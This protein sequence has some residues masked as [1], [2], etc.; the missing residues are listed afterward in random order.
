MADAQPAGQQRVR[1]PQVGGVGHWGH[2]WE[3]GGPQG[4]PGP[5]AG[6]SLWPQSRAASPAPAPAGF[7][8]ARACPWLQ[9]RLRLPLTVC[10]L[11]PVGTPPG[12]DP[13]R[14]P[15]GFRLNPLGSPWV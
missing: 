10:R 5:V 2:G 15:D 8:S 12:C 4:Q 7:S 6:A 1:Q 14:L 11:N 9:P 13:A 3:V